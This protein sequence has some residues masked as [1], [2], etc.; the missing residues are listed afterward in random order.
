MPLEPTIFK[1][2]I[3][4]RGGEDDV[5]GEGRWDVIIVEWVGS[6][7]GDVFCGEGSGVVCCWESEGVGWGL[8]DNMGDGWE[9]MVMR[10][11]HLY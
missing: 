1:G 5:Y 2:S 10:S 3:E 6:F 7:Y 8:E 4:I 9:C 11:V